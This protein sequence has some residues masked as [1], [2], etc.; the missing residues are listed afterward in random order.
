VAG[1]TNLKLLVAG[2]VLSLLVGT[3]SLAPAKEEGQIDSKAFR[4]QLLKT[5]KLRP[6]KARIF[7][8]VEEK[9]DRIRQE[10]LERITKSAEQ[11][12]KLLSGE[13]PDEGKLKELTTAMAGDQDIL[14][15]TYKSRR[16]ETMALLTPVQQGEYLLFTWKWQQKLLA[17]Y[18][19][20]TTGQQDKGKKAKAP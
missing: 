15:N 16:D 3:P 12:E 2:I 11:L 18:G 14:V 19:K 8:H 20:H 10:A 9:Y 17:K 5:L 1:H 6:D 4:S 13:K 7:M